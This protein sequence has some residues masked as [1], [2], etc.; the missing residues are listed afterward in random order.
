MKIVEVATPDIGSTEAVDVI[1]ILVQPGDKIIAG[2]SLITVESEKASVEI[3][4]SHSG[5]LKAFAVAIGDKINEGTILATMEIDDAALE[6]LVQE[7]SSING[8][9]QNF[10]T[11]QKNLTSDRNDDDLEISTS[12]KQDSILCQITKSE[13]LLPN[14]SPSVRK[15][16]RELTADLRVISGTGRNG[17]IQREDV[18]MYVKSVLSSGAQGQIEKGSAHSNTLTLV[19]WPSVDFT[20]YGSIESKPLSRIQKISG[21]NLHRNWVKIP[22]VTQFDETDI[23]DLEQ[24]RKD[25]NAKNEVDVRLT[26]LSFAIKASVTALKKFPTFNSSL[27]ATGENLIIKHYYNIGFAC[28]TPKGLIVPVIQQADEKSVKHIAREMEELS[29]QAR[30]GK[31]K[32]SNMS[33]ATFTISSLGGIGGLAF[34]PIINA[35]EVAILGLSRAQLKP[36]WDGSGFQPRLMMPMSLSYDHRVIDGVR[37]AQFSQFLSLLLSDIRRTII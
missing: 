35:P 19:P 37:G 1:E 18:Q 31:L 2:Q 23:T 27:D 13:I 6:D 14:A 8:S 33:G 17:R 9:L 12:D 24:F 32:P 36:I 20:K 5:I 30:E 3:P 4:V 21:M 16:A 10:D 15:Y 26:L 7:N 22:H 29:L 34:T 11:E 25:L 28:D